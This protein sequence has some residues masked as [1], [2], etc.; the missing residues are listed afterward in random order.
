MKRKGHCID[1]AVKSQEQKSVR[2]QLPRHKF[3]AAVKRK[4]DVTLL[5][6]LISE[7]NTTHQQAHFMWKWHKERKTQKSFLAHYLRV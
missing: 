1:G 7:L 3:S 5:T 2:G 4:E 6:T